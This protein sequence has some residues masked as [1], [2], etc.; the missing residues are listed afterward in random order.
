MLSPTDCPMNW[1]TLLALILEFSIPQS[2]REWNWRF[3]SHCPGWCSES[4]PEVDDTKVSNY[5]G[6]ILTFKHNVI[7]MILLSRVAVV[8]VVSWYYDWYSNYSH[9]PHS[10]D[11]SSWSYTIILS[12][13]YTSNRILEFVHRLCCYDNSKSYYLRA[14]L[15]EWHLPN[16]HTEAI[17][18]CKK[19][20]YKSFSHM[21]CV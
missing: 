4:E 15:N 7:S 6:P 13:Q 12:C 2:W 11:T 10:M 9:F 8:S 20:M 18:M 16:H 17:C 1:F 3:W 21:K 19:L 14:F 5:P